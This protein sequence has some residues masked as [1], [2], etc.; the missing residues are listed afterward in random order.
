M[1][2]KYKI[3]QNE[4]RYL[5]IIFF[6]NLEYGITLNDTTQIVRAKKN[7]NILLLKLGQEERNISALHCTLEA[8]GLWL[9]TRTGA[10]GTATLTESFFSPQSMAPQTAAG[11]W[12]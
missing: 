12:A 2:L 11:M 3:I 10:G 8:S 7:Y 9:G 6:L 4:Y 1:N 5:G